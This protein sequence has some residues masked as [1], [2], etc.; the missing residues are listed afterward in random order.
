MKKTIF[1]LSPILAAS[2]CI[3]TVVKN[4]HTAIGSNVYDFENAEIIL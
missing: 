2:V 1:Y 4:S 3:L